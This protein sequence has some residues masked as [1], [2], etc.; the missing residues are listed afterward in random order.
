MFGGSTRFEHFW[1]L[2]KVKA[3]IQTFYIHFL[4]FKVMKCHLFAAINDD[5]DLYIHRKHS[6]DDSIRLSV[7]TFNKSDFEIGY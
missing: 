1:N 5:A 6:C 3:G 4:F 2:E 7:M